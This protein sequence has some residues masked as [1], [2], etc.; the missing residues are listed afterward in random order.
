M[1]KLRMDDGAF[2]NWRQ[3]QESAVEAHLKHHALLI[4]AGWVWDGMDGY[5]APGLDTEILDAC[6][7]NKAP[8]PK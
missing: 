7:D 8:F 4:A 2:S 6:F 5:M 1:V 3:Q